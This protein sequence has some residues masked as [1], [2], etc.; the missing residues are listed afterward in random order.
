VE[1]QRDGYITVRAARRDDAPAL[2]AL[3][4]ALADYEQLDRPDAAARAR[5]VADGFHREPRRFEALLA[6]ARGDEPGEEHE[7][8][9]GYAIF[10]ETYSSFLARPTLYIEDLFVLPERRERGAGAALFARL[11]R[12]AVDRDCGRM[13]WVVL[14]WNRLA[15]DFYERRGGRHLA[16]WQTYRLTREQ[17]EGLTTNR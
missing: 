2:L 15:K 16:E 7:A 12:E 13:E 10:F 8:P 17:L 1:N 9:V 5:L 14:D 6:V 4:D 11:A 3:V